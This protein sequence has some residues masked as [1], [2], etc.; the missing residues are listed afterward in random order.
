MSE[1]AAFLTFKPGDVVVVEPG[2]GD[3]AV[4]QKETW[5]MGQILWCEG[6]ARDPTVPTLFQVVNVDTGIVRWINADEATRLVIDQYEP[7]QTDEFVVTP[8]CPPKHCPPKPRHSPGRRL[9]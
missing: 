3:S 4:Q 8:H 5:W 2:Q 9:T 7:E 6:G 1:D